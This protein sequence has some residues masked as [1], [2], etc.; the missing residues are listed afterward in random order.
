[1]DK[2]WALESILLKMLGEQELPAGALGCRP[3]LGLSREFRTRNV[4][5]PQLTA[6]PDKDPLLPPSTGPRLLPRNPDPS[7]GSPL[8]LLSISH[9]HLQLICKSRWLC[10]QNTPGIWQLLTTLS[11]S[12]GPGHHHHFLPGD[13]LVPLWVP[14]RELDL[15]TNYSPCGSQ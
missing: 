14:S 3:S 10:L 15:S 6:D 8:C 5:N 2:Q 12:P 7:P 9:L 1:M 11:L 4:Y 13:A